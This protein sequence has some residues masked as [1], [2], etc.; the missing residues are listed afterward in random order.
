MRICIFT[1]DIGKGAMHQLAMT[2]AQNCI[3]LGLDTILYLPDSVKIDSDCPIRQNIRPYKKVKSLNPWN[4]GAMNV[5][6]CICN[7]PPE[8]FIAVEDS[9]FTMQVLYNLPTSICKT[10]MIHDIVMHPSNAGLAKRVNL[11]ISKNVFRK[12]GM[13]KADFITLLSHNSIQRFDNIYSSRKY[14]TFLFP[15][16]AH[17]PY[18]KTPAKPKELSISSNYILFFGRIDKYK[19]V[20]TLV[21]AYNDSNCTYNLVIAGKGV[22][23]ES[24]SDIIAT[25]PNIH[26]LQRFIEDEEMIWLFQNS[27]VI[28]LPYKEASQSGVLP[29]A[30][31]YGKPVLASNIE[32]LKELIDIHK[33]GELFASEDELRS[34]LENLDNWNF[35][36]MRDFCIQYSNANF[37]WKSNVKKMIKEFIK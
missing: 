2:L 8:M 11:W 34:Q 25:N 21:K 29:I 7:R 24:I 31:H 37:E 22:L 10:F 5:A 35:D 18:Y 30:Y 15:L 13:L 33:T 36:D 17:V 9:I 23:D 32:G 27:K 12:L 20:D 16:G 28:S 19:G 26:I 1:A 14:K 3:E 4:E 6:K